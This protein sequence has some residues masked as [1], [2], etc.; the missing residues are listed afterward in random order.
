MKTSLGGGGLLLIA[1]LSLLAIPGCHRA[2]PGGGPQAQTAVQALA[3]TQGWPGTPRLA[4]R[5]MLEKYGPPQRIQPDRLDWDGRWP[6][7]RMS[8]DASRISRPLEQV[9]DYDVPNSRR[10]ALL[11][12][13][14]G[15]ILYAE[16]GELA[17]R[18]DREEFNFLTLNLAHEIVRGARGPAEARFF[19]AQICR[20]AQTG[21]QSPYTSGLLFSHRPKARL[22]K[23]KR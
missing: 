4:A 14:H 3:A 7:K 22:T 15:L 18:S 2:G 11:R 17:A 10:A 5:L 21:K 20:L 19:H 9:L 23:F 1:A 6:W 16:E 13:R 12:F 8:V